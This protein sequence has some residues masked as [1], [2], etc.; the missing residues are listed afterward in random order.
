MSLIQLSFSVNCSV[1][2]HEMRKKG[3]KEGYKIARYPDEEGCFQ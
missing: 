2:M 1:L 3:M